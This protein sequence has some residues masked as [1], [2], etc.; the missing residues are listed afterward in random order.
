M[1]DNLIEKIAWGISRKLLQAAYT[2][3]S[4]AFEVINTIR[5]V[6]GFKDGEYYANIVPYIQKYATEFEKTKA[7]LHKVNIENIDLMQ[8]LDFLTKKIEKPTEAKTNIK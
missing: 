7:E 4:K 5:T 2:E 6:I 1:F 3:N 8:K